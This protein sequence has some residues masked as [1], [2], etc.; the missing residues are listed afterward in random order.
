MSLEE[1]LPASLRGGE[2]TIT[3][4]VAGLS[5]A[6]VYRVEAAGRAFVLKVAAAT[7]SIEEWRRRAGIQERA[8]QAGL[9]PAIVHI[10]ETR[11]AVVSAFVVDR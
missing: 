3:R 7:E 6:G 9:A 2:T 5:G 10:D 11:R 1:C 4:V 8:A